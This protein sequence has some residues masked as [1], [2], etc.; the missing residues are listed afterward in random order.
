MLGGKGDTHELRAAAGDERDAID[1]LLD[2]AR[3]IV[4][5][6]GRKINQATFDRVA[7][8]LQAAGAD[9]RLGELVR[10]GRLAK[11]A[12]SATLGASTP[13]PKRGGRDGRGGARTSRTS[14][15]RAE[16]LAEARADLKGAKREATRLEAEV[17]RGRA[18][19]KKVR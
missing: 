2:A 3:R 9:E 19:V 16:R 7:E 12:R 1:R 18:R 13:G 15:K 4:A 6:D 14:E 17:G 11:E 8:T 5:E 10:A